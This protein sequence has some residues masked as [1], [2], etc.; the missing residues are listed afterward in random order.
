MTNA[1]LCTPLLGG[2]VT[3]DVDKLWNPDFNE[4]SG[5]AQNMPELNL[6]EYEW[7]GGVDMKA[8]QQKNGTD[9][10]ILIHGFG[11]GVFSWRHIMGPLARQTGQP[12]V[13]FDRPGWGLTSRPG[14]AEWEEKKMSNP[15]ELNTQ[16]NLLFSFCREMGFSSV[17][18]VG[19]D[20][21]GLLA[22]MAAERAHTTNQQIEVKGV[23]LVSVSLT[24]E[25]VPAF[26]RI[27]LHTSLGQHM[28]RPLLRTEISQVANRRAWFDATKLTSDVLDL[29]KAPLCIEGW[30]RA[31]REVGKLS[32]R[33]VLSAQMLQNY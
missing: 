1:S 15:Y 31:L 33:A 9:G 25:V 7:P 21:G 27:L 20:D 28:L 2:S 16:V 3:V 4:H 19:H 26:A 8:G 24:R 30:D 29:Y 18:L 14:R 6:E 32:S 11:G 13:A 23:V 10:I 12:V 22:L 5:F 17:V